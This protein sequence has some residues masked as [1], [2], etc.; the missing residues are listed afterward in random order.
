MRRWLALLAALCGTL[1]GTLLTPVGAADA[2]TG[3]TVCSMPPLPGSPALRTLHRRI[4]AGSVTRPVRMLAVGSSTTYGMGLAD[5]SQR[6]PDQLAR[7]LRPAYVAM[8]DA[9]VPGAFAVDYAALALPRL[10]VTR[11]QVVLHMIGA[12]DY[13]MHEPPRVFAAGL[14]TGLAAMD[15]Q[16]VRPIQVLVATYRDPATEEPSHPWSAYRAAMRR[17]AAEDPRHR[18]F[19][20]L[21]PWFERAGVPGADPAGYLDAGGVH[22]SAKGQA[23]IARL[24][25]RAL[26]YGC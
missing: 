25:L 5:L 4:A 24:V 23:T 22:P 18:L 11:P 10:L 7:D 2:T 26:G 19:V 20:D 13:W 14:R 3:P 21:T 17:T 12:N 9:A 6:W 16:P 15:L 8:N 1:L